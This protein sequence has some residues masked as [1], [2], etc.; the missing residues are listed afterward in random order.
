M[1]AEELDKLDEA[2]DRAARE[3]TDVDAPADLTARV[4]ARIEAPPLIPWR[5]VA[6][7]AL[8]AALVIVTLVLVR[9]RD[10]GIGRQPIDVVRSSPPVEA[11]PAAAPPPQPAADAD[12]SRDAAGHR[13]VV[14]AAMTADETEPPAGIDPLAVI[15]PIA[16]DALEHE[17]FAPA[18]ISIVPLAP[19]AEIEVE[20]LSPSS[21][22][23]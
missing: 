3:L 13:R 16:M 19:I 22:R 9:S 6:A 15:D 5:R 7:G 2:I 18:Q 20:P 1:N 12:R 14:A 4:L 11:P 8:V 17:S 23:N 21:G 10:S